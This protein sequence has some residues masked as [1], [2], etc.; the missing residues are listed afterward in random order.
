MANDL[1]RV[2]LI[3]TE[4]GAVDFKKTLQD[5]NLELNKNYNQFK[6][7]Q[8]QWDSSTKSTEKLKAQQEYLTN[9]YEIQQ[10]KVATLKMQLADLENAEDKNTTA[11]KKKRNELTNAEIKLEDYNNKLKDIEKQLNNSGKKIEEFGTKIE[12]AGGKVENA[13]KKVSAF[14]I[15]T[16]TALVASAK[17]AIEFESAFTGVE[18]TV[19]GT[20]QQMA[21]LKQG[22][23]D[24]AKEI[25]SSTTEI[26]AV[27]EAAG[28]LGIK[29]EDI[30]S[31]TR[32]MIDLGNSTNLSAEEAASALAKF[33]NITNMS[34]Q[35]Y[36][37][38]GAT[39]VDLGNNFATTEADIVEMA[40]RLAATGELAGLSQAQI[41]ALATAMS[42]VGIEAEA[43]GSAMSKLLK[44]IQ[45][46]V[47]TG[48][49]DLKD[50]AKVAGMSSSEFKKAFEQDAVKALSAFISGL[51]D[52]ERN[53]KSAIVILEE[54][55]LTEVRLSNTVLSLANASD[56][57]TDAIDTASTAWEDNT[58][59][60]N[61]ANKRYDT[62]ESKIKICINKLKDF[63]ITIGNKLM[64]SIEKIV[65]KIGDFAE[66]LS[67]LSEEQVDFIVNI[68]LMV[69]AIGPL[70]TIFGK[71]TSTTG[72]II[73]SIGTFTQA[74]GVVKGTVTT[75][76]TAVNG[77]AGIIGGLTSPVGLAVTAVAALAGGLVYLA[78]R[79]TEAQKK[80]QEFAEE[81]QNE[82]EAFEE[83]NEN[84]DKA[85]S[86]NLAQINSVERLKNEL[87][88]L[89]DANGKVK[90]GYEGRVSFILNEL[91]GALD[92]EYRLNGNIVQS[93]KNLQSEIDKT[94][95]KK[96]AEAILNGEQEK[97]A[98]AVS[99]EEEAVKNATAA[100]E[101][102]LEVLDEYG[103]T[104]EELREK[105]ANS[106]GKEKEY[107]DNVINAYDNTTQILKQNTDIQKQYANDYALFMEG[108]YNEIGQTVM[109]TTSNWTNSSLE[110]I[111]N[112]IT[113]QAK[114]L[115]NYKAIYEQTGSE[116]ARTQM[117][118]A[119][120]NLTNLTNELTSRTSTITSMSAGEITA[121]R[122]LGTESYQNYSEAIS[123]MEPEM[124]Q[125]IQN[126]TGIVASNTSLPDSASGLASRTTGYFQS[127]LDFER[128]EADE[129]KGASG[130]LNRDTSVQNEAGN[131]AER[132]QTILE[133][134]DSSK[135][136][137]DMVEGL[138][139]GIRSKGN[140][141]WFT[142]I[143]SGLASK[144]SSYLHFSRP[145]TGPL[146]EYEKW[147]PDMVEGLGR[148]LEK[149]SPKLI[150]KVKNMSEEMSDELKNINY[151][152]PKNTN[153]NS[154]TNTI[155]RDIDYEKMANA[156]LKAL[157]N[158][159]FTLDEDGFAKIVKDELYKVV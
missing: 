119:E 72:T 80:A 28:Q 130:I 6:L 106:S 64:P 59:L 110:T 11:I 109:N 125:K 88:T 4:E 151:G 16:G 118:Q 1:K 84:I 103:M 121:W 85:T 13:G 23:R 146:R 66:W 10:D 139:K 101:K 144:I 141:S 112:S 159:K 42:S 77:L 24:M 137:S 30:L 154:N 129:L 123:K 104:L 73:K 131:L 147:M 120:Q 51:N 7:T 124:Q 9:A 63:A 50:F 98:N 36:S 155:I 37:K 58:A 69:T 74:V 133:S 31:F 111:R 142:S 135:W 25:P 117:E 15:A 126:M 52:T 148:T 75:T 114:A 54:M 21:E 48:S 38:L 35:D 40:T 56:V 83:Y 132:T 29:T 122:T 2:G 60:T 61:E 127:L 68:G 26:S 45:V 33:A 46:A 128:V 113:E 145:D 153:I 115:E 92:T 43:G 55:G 41:L 93:Y 34:A 87:S 108:K 57:M 47:E 140:S 158:C 12:K 96:R 3:F 79:Q 150:S 105:A 100:R 134:N 107:L 49:D 17:S 91:N 27:A 136:G 156:M 81:M 70:L 90:E 86:S 8:A 67:S 97:Y 152:T 5:I 71:L 19:D 138:G 89:V 76:S 44:Q 143:L 18:K 157:T 62:L 78:T 82:K 65:D 102:L 53:G 116:V 95:E 94:I 20:E 99:E 14:S 149:S 22:I 32:V 39:I